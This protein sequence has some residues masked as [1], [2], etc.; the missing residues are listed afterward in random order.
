MGKG[1]IRPIAICVFRRDNR[2]LV[3]EGY[4][5]VKKESFYRPL[6]G[7]IEFGEKSQE[8]IVREIREELGAE[9]TG[10]RYLGTVENIFTFN[11]EAGHEIV[12]VYDGTFRDES[13]YTRERLQGY[14]VDEA[15]QGAFT[16]VWMTLDDLR[17]GDVPLYP[18]ALLELLLG[19]RS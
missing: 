14:E 4:D 6:G 13:L 9:V 18:D 16:A 7:R 17:E 5:P 3:G 8:T 15:W 1:H 11:G 2:I 12:Q 10:L 19:E